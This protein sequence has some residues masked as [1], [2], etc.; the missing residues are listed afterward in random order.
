MAAPGTNSD[1][2]GDDSDGQQAQEMRQ[3]TSSGCA[4]G[5]ARGMRL[6]TSSGMR[7]GTSSGDAPG[8]ELGGCAG[9]RARGMRCRPTVRALDTRAGIARYAALQGHRPAS[10]HLYALKS[11]CV[12]S[13]FA[14]PMG[15]AWRPWAAPPHASS[16]SI[17]PRQWYRL[18]Y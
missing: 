5:R 7:L 2:P 1:V 6:G 3:G 17:T 4:G 9:G 18:Y 14:S 10:A 11:V 16:A 8:D 13:M 12:V 15:M